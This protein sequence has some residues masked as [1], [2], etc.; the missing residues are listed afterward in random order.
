MFSL[1]IKIKNLQVDGGG[2][3][4]ANGNGVDL[5]R[6]FPDQFHDKTD[7]DS[8]VRGREVETLA[9]MKFIASNPFVLSG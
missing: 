1:I 8:L 2:I 9:A 6:N 5:N 7:H 4:R 3:G